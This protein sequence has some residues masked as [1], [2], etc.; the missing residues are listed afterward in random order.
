[1]TKVHYA[2]D[3]RTFIS[4]GFDNR[5][6]IWENIAESIGRCGWHGPQVKEEIETCGSVTA[7][8]WTNKDQFAAGFV[9]HMF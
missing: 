3:G 5:V 2:P 6:R 1:M 4:V 8:V 7:A 9:R